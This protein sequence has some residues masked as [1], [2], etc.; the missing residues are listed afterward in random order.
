MELFNQT[1]LDYF[2]N[3]VQITIS[4]QSSFAR[5]NSN[6]DSY[7]ILGTNSVDNS[8][9]DLANSSHTDSST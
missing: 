5:I 7:S 1:D 6:F 8:G 9:F 3:F 2:Q 4:F